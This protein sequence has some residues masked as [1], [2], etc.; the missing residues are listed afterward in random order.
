MVSVGDP[1]GSGFVASLARPG[2]NITGLSNITA[3]LSAK[4]LALFAEL[5]PGMK[6]VGIVSNVYNPNVA[7]QLRETEDAVAKLG[8]ESRVVDAHTLEELV[9]AFARLSAE[10][11]NGERR[12]GDDSC[13]FSVRDLPRLDARAR[14]YP[15]VEDVSPTI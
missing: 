4:L 13:S 9:R 14:R 15:S 7:I 12:R 5:V 8:L 6:R 2:G 10:R 3:D 1:V 11:V